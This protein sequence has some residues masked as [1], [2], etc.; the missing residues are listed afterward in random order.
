VSP[1][2]RAVSGF[3]ASL[4]DVFASFGPIRAQ[5]MFGGYG[6]FRDDLMFALVAG[7]VLYLKA[8]EAMAA[9]LAAREL[10]PFEYTKQGRR[11][12]IG[13]FTAPAEVFDDPDEAKRWA[14]KAYAAALRGKRR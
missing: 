14:Q 12:Q 8:D 1:K 9:E 13:Y 4:D 2:A 7:D 5:R 3:V 11:M 6:I 10:G